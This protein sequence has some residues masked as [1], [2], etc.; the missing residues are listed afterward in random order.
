M[1]IECRS[2]GCG[3]RQAT[4]RRFG[5]ASSLALAPA[6]IFLPPSPFS[7]LPPSSP[8]LFHH[9]RQNVLAWRSFLL[10][11]SR[12]CPLQGRKEDRGGLVWCHLRRSAFL[13]SIPSP[14]YSAPECHAMKLADAFAHTGTNLLNSQTVAIKFVRGARL[15]CRLLPVLCEHPH[16]PFMRATVWRGSENQTR[17]TSFPYRNLGNRMRRN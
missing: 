6:L 10:S 17:L 8:S 15:R 1:L 11:K 7:L 13:P 3:K 5:K 2:C 16:S 9:R 12:R 4:R 14:R